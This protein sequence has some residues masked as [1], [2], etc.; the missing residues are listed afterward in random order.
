M[1]L[2][3]G[4]IEWGTGAGNADPSTWDWSTTKNG[5][6]HSNLHNIDIALSHDP[7]LQRIAWYDEF[8]DR[9]LTGPTGREWADHDDVN[10]ALRLQDEYRLSGIKPSQVHDALDHRV[11]GSS[12][13]CVREWLQSLAWDRV[14]RIGLAF[15][16]H[17]GVETGDDQPEAYVRAASA[18]FFIGLVARVMRP[19]CQ[20]DTMVVF[21]GEQGIRKSTALR[22]LGGPWYATSSD[23]ASH[24]DFFQSLKGKWLVEVSELESFSKTEVT[25]V[26]SVISTPVDRY[27]SSY[28]R[29]PADHPR[30]C[31]F[32]GTTN[33]DNWGRDETG[34]R[35]FWPVRCGLINATALAASRDLLFAEAVVRYHERHSWWEMPT[36]AT[37]RV[38]AD[39]QE[40]HPWTP[41]VLAYL[42]DKREATVDEILQGP[43]KVAV[44]VITM[45]SSHDVGRILR[46]SGWTKVTARRAG[47]L[48]KVWV[49]PSEV[50]TE[51]S[52]ASV[53]WGN[54]GNTDVEKF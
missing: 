30:Q 29:T 18:N 21:E 51:N 22:I 42:L 14:D 26:K 23:S 54:G 48:G 44:P 33:A 10:L 46:L 45:K 13:H 16:D 31:V 37:A 2:K 47:Q 43:L 3:S 9:I 6:K 1:T 24:K 34:L 35:R 27:R 41:T 5:T 36:R 12:R 8:L 53:K 28:G 25:R 50:D 7:T 15:E 19:G 40:E 17:W 4:D 49:A 52:V 38:Q 39:R 32:A 11:R 20:L